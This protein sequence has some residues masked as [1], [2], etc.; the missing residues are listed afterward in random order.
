[1]GTA[2]RSDAREDKRACRRLALRGIYRRG[3]AG[4]GW[5]DGRWEVEDPDPDGDLL[6]PESFLG[7]VLPFSRPTA[8]RKPNW[9]NRT[10]RCSKPARMRPMSSRRIAARSRA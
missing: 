10:A 5:R 7:N 8:S 1:T 6:W 2:A 9:P 3:A 4:T